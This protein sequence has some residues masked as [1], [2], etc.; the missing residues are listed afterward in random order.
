MTNKEFYT[1]VSN[2]NI[3]EDVIAHAT[4]ALRKME[5]ATTARA[6][7]KNAEDAPLVEAV[8]ALLTNAPR[9][10]TAAEI[11]AQVGVHT[12]KA[13]NLCKKIPNIRISDV[14]VDRRVVKGYSL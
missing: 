11:A 1:A 14:T 12:S 7:A 9:V 4:E 5:E 13:T 3:T 2:N 8:V 10:Y 6:T